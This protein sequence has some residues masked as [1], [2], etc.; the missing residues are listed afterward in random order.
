MLKRDKGNG[1]AVHDNGLQMINL[2]H[3]KLL[4]HTNFVMSIYYRGSYSKS[5]KGY[6]ITYDSKKQYLTP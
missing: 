3:K 5:L 4:C 6:I 1:E 2:S